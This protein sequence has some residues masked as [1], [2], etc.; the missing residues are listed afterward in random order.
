M[1]RF[2]SRRY[3]GR[4]ATI[5]SMLAL[6]TAGAIAMRG[7]EREPVERLAAATVSVEELIGAVTGQRSMLRT[8]ALEAGPWDLPNLRHE[9]VD[10]WVSRF[11]TVPEMREKFEGFLVRSG[12]YVPMISAK[13]AERGMPQDL[14]FLA[15]IE[16]GFQPHAYSTASASGLWQFI[17]ETGER[18]GLAIDRAVDERRDPER[19]TDA[20]L[21]YLEDLH[22]R[23]NSWYLAA[24]A[25][26]TGENRVGR[27]MR[28]AYGTER[29]SSEEAYYGIWDALPRETRD[30]VPLMIAA[31]RIA[32]APVRYGFD[33]VVPETP[34]PYDEVVVEPATDLVAIA[35]AAGISVDEL[36][37]L[38]PH[39]RIHRT[40]NDR[41]Y[42]VRVPAGT[43]LRLTHLDLSGGTG[44]AGATA[45]V[46]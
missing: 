18:Y 45:V 9:R 12:R 46:E 32:R 39:F 10:Y 4:T 11:D 33:H 42:R 20:A 16:S 14:I 34:A 24:A 8:S 28:E 13:L 41:D 26:N 40:P 5:V 44:S 29:A 1:T 38:N 3:R 36:K 30:Y 21:D 6:V 7:T 19:A 43:A 37:A 22:D 31:G 17:A 35:G 25:Y 23:F 2:S 27:I 15:M